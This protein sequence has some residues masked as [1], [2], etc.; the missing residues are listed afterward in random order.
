MLN[1]YQSKHNKLL[2]S[3]LVFQGPKLIT[4]EIRNRWG[5]GFL[6]SSLPN[7]DAKSLEE[8]ENK[9]K[10][11]NQGKI[12]LERVKIQKLSTNNNLYDA[13]NEC[14]Y[15]ACFN[16]LRFVQ[17]HIIYHQLTSIKSFRPK[18]PIFEKPNFKNK[19]N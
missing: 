6:C 10:N 13:C 4:L 17:Y 14:T 18:I 12:V 7:H 3:F 16:A 19:P 15:D 8:K 2:I 9:K 1:P 5:G 11:N